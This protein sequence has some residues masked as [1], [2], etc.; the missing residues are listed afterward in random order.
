MVLGGGGAPLLQPP[1]ASIGGGGSGSG[2][3][4]GGSGGG[5]LAS[6]RSASPGLKLATAATKVSAVYDSA[7]DS[8]GGFG[9]VGG[10]GR[11]A[12]RAYPVRG[13]SGSVV[14]V[15]ARTRQEEMDSA[16]D[17]VYWGWVVLGAT[18]VVFVV[19]MGSV[20]GVWQWAWDVP[21]VSFYSS[22]FAF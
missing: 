12:Q 8:E 14:V 10:G 16:A 7:D 22:C 15:M 19:G 6:R 5:S 18:W 11:M 17:T 9:G 4:G 13:R 2:G 1:P 3:G 20:L 21:G